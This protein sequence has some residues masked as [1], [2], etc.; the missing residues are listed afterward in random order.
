MEA[1]TFYVNYRNNCESCSNFLW[2]LIANRLTSL[3]ATNQIVPNIIGV[4]K[5]N[6]QVI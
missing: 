2:S 1:L 5:D 6:R 4:M 3:D